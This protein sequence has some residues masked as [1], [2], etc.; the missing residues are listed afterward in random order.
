MTTPKIHRLFLYKAD[1]ARAVVTPSRVGRL[2]D[3]RSS[4]TIADDDNRETLL[5]R[6]KAAR[7]RRDLSLEDE[8]RPHSSRRR[9]TF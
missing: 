2:H 7:A 9:T 3:R 8:S 5:D 4:A 6:Q 1:K